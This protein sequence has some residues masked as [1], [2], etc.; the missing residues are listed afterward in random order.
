MQPWVK[1]NVSYYATPWENCYFLHAAHAKP[2]FLTDGIIN[3]AKSLVVQ[4]GHYQ[5]PLLALKEAVSAANVHLSDN[6]LEDMASLM[7]ENGTRWFKARLADGSPS[8]LKQADLQEDMV[9]ARHRVREE[10]K[11]RGVLEDKAGRVAEVWCSKVRAYHFT[12]R[13]RSRHEIV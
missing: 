13:V 7:H 4:K 12:S 8:R 1:P 3:Q 11:N 10:L 9:A 2:D 5:D 6:D